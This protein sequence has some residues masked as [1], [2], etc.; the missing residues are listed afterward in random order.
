MKGLKAQQCLAIVTFFQSW[1]VKSILG[2]G[3]LEKGYMVNWCMLSGV[4]PVT[5]VIENSAL[6]IWSGE[7]C[8]RLE[9]QGG[10]GARVPAQRCAVAV[11]SAAGLKARVL[12]RLMPLAPPAFPPRLLRCVDVL[13]VGLPAGHF[14]VVGG[15]CFAA[16][17]GLVWQWRRSLCLLFLFDDA[18]SVFVSVNIAPVVFVVFFR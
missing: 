14:A 18:L 6:T 5:V 13:R 4:G 10:G 1:L 16:R 12:V 9:F 15:S 3:L 7:F 17:P 11:F 2:T 8:G